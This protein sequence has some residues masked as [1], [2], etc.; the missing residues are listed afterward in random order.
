MLLTPVLMQLIIT[1]IIKYQSDGVD[2]NWPS[3]ESKF[4]WFWFFFLKE[5]YLWSNSRFNCRKLRLQQRSKIL[6][7][8]SY[9]HTSLHF[10]THLLAIPQPTFLCS[11]WNDCSV[12]KR[13]KHV[14]QARPF[15]RIVGPSHQVHL[16][17][18]SKLNTRLS[19]AVR[20]PWAAI[21]PATSFSDAP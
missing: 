15:T 8:V 9:T 7:V 4:H 12:G 16:D 10:Q 6:S 1:V 21:E 5:A 18:N 17:A 13:Y 20:L 11:T 2:V 3:G 14:M 19:A